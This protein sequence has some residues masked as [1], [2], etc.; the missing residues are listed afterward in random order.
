[1]KENFDDEGGVFNTSDSTHFAQNVGINVVNE[2]TDGKM[3]VNVNAGSSQGDIAHIDTG[4]GYIPDTDWHFYCI[5]YDQSLPSN[6]FKLTRDNGNLEQA[7]KT[8]ATPSSG[9]HA[10][11]ALVG[12]HTGSTSFFG[13]S[14]S[15]MS[16]WNRVLTSSEITTLYNS[17]NGATIYSYNTFNAPNGAIFEESDTGK[18]Y[19]WDGSTTWNEVT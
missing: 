11:T 8:S 12:V 9:S 1:M 4:D 7:T 17:G 16:V 10:Q 3:I 2:S 14:L 5:T 15:E 18:H 6:N 13:G 19:M